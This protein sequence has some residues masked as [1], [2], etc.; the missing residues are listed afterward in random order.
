MNPLWYVD[1]VFYEVPVYAFFD[2]NGDGVGDFAGLTEKLDYLEWLGITCIWL[3]PFYESPLRDGGYD[4][5]DFRSILSRYGTVDD[6]RAFLEE[7]HQRGLRVIADMIVN[8]TSDQHPWFQE[9][10][11]P[12]SPLRSRYVWSDTPDRFPDARVIFTDTHHSN[13]TWDPV[14]GAYY[15]H[16][17]FDHQPDLNFDDPAVRDEIEGI[18]RFWLTLGFDGLRLDAV[19]YLY[20]RDDTNGENLPETHAYLKRLRAMVDAEF[21]DR[22]LLAEA[23]QWPDNVVEYFGEG[24]EFH[25]AYHFPLMPR[26]FMA[27]AQGDAGAVIDVLENTPDIP[28]GC[29]WGIF[30]RNHDEL[31]LEMVTD[32]ERQ[33]LWDRYAPEPSMRKNI[34]IRRR[35]APLLD[36]DR[37]RIELLHA[38]LLSLPGSPFLYYGDEIGMGDEHLLDD[39]DGVRTPMQWDSSPTAGFSTAGPQDL[40]LPVV[41][42]P[43]YSPTAVNVAAQRDD[44]GSLLLWTRKMLDL[45]SGLSALGAGAFQ[46]VPASESAVFAF[47]RSGADAT[48]LVVANFSDAPVVS[49]LDMDLTPTATLA[50][51]PGTSLDETTITLDPHGWGWFQVERRFTV[52]AA[53]H[54]D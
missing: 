12:G 20:E 5:S 48:V 38:L 41:S 15:W 6:V 39:R 35:L 42:S 29:R 47:V 44:P 37:R 13:W 49:D 53:R 36:G 10:R 40:Y 50:A 43:G 54:G 7:A 26:L 24:D 1:A 19:P 34:G 23:N 31:T 14:A 9:A 21:D 17:F 11:L 25:M 32:E 8:H 3:L 51:A 2:T 46:M 28:D 45:R 52:I 33:Y 22:M 4:I 27:L 16:R 30:L 18:I